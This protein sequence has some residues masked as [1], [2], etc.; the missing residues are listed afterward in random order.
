MACVNPDGTISPSASALLKILEEP[1]S[2]GEIAGKL[3]QP[4]FRVR[5]S[6]RE[7]TE[8][9]FIEQKEDKYAITEAGR[10]KI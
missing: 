6:L 7:M 1:L 3:G 2:P 4:L 9:G 10:E 5:I 8:A